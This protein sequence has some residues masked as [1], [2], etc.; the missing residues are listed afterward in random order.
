MDMC[1]NG[2]VYDIYYCDLEMYSGSLLSDLFDSDN[3]QWFECIFHPI[4][5]QLKH[6]IRWYKVDLLL[7][8]EL[9]QL[10]TL[11]KPNIPQINSSLT[12]LTCQ[13]IIQ[14]QYTFRHP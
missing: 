1:I 3:K 14:P 12:E 11:M 10:N 9:I 6:S 7:F 13:L 5:H 8:S 4:T 2:C